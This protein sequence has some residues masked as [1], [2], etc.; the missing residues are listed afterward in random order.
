MEIYQFSLNKDNQKRTDI[1]QVIN[2]HLIKT[3]KREQTFVKLSIVTK[4]R[5]SKI[6]EIIF[7]VVRFHLVHFSVQVP[8]RFLSESSRGLIG[9][10]ELCIGFSDIVE[11][12]GQ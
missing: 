3:N 2:S 6:G 12:M 4:Y 7:S 9:T 11:L 5:I 1:S 8:T 10:K